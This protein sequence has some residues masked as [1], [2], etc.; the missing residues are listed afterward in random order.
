MY[1]EFSPVSPAPLS[2]TDPSRKFQLKVLVS[3][4]QLLSTETDFVVVTKNWAKR[5]WIYDSNSQV[6]LQ[7]KHNI[8][9]EQLD[10]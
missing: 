7:M 3:S 9:P 6:T 8:V 5:K 2:F 4:L 10:V 1:R